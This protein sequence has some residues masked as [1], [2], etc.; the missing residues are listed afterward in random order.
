MITKVIATYADGAKEIRPHFKNGLPGKPH[1]V[2]V[3]GYSLTEKETAKL[4]EMRL[5]YRQ[6]TLNGEYLRQ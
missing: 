2:Q 5:E 4:Q 3:A 1:L 6:V